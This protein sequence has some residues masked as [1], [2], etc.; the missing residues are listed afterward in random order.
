MTDSAMMDNGNSTTT[1]EQVSGS[2]PGVIQL[3]NDSEA[4][5]QPPAPVPSSDPA[6]SEPQTTSTPPEEPNLF[7]L[8]AM[9]ALK[10]LSTSVELLVRLTGDIPPT[11]PPKISLTPQMSDMQAEKESIVRSHS[12]TNLAELRRQTS[13]L[14]IKRPWDHDNSIDGVQLKAPASPTAPPV[15]LQHN[16]ITRKF[17]SKNE[18]PISIGQ[19]LTRLHQFCP[20]SSAVYLATSLYIH[21]LA[22]EERAIPVTRRN[23]HRLVLAGLRVAMKALEDLAYAHGKFAKVGGVS[24]TELARLE[25]SF[26][27]LTGF[28][29][30][31]GEETLTR[32]WEELRSGRAENALRELEKVP[33][34]HLPPRKDA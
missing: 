22:V 12:N 6:L 21:R 7:T 32:H 20:M 17:Y 8:P 30:V 9:E 15:N 24:E 29:L 18:P 10:L 1:T 23:A 28:E 31:V 27:F 26:C 14:G 3:Q 16:A 25:I 34:L 5:V 4:A 19:Y 13:N 11:P 33:S 2:S